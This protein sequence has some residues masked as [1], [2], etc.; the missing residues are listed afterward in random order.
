MTFVDPK[1]TSQ[2]CSVCGYVSRS[3][4]PDQST[5]SCVSC[6]HSANADTNAAVNIAA[7]AAINQPNEHLAQ[8][9]AAKPQLQT[10][11]LAAG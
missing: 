10:L 3:N 9:S 2:M 4:R 7:R 6:G 11:P 5:F 1:Y 8:G